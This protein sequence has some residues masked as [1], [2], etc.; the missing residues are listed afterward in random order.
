MSA[1]FGYSCKSRHQILDGLRISYKQITRQDLDLL[2][3]ARMLM[4]LKPGLRWAV[5][6]STVPA[7]ALFA[8]LVFDLNAHL[9]LPVGAATAE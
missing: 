1:P 9:S 6:S 5:R 7:S 8:L 2:S 4:L 3:P